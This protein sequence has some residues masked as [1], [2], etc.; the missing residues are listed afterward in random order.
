MAL[1][2]T[3][4]QIALSLN[5]ILPIHSAYFVSVVSNHCVKRILLHFKKGFSVPLAPRSERHGGRLPPAPSPAS[6]RVYILTEELAEE[7]NF[8]GSVFQELIPVDSHRRRRTSNLEGLQNC[9]NLAD[10]WATKGGCY[11]PWYPLFYA[12]VNSNDINKLYKGMK[13][14]KQ[15]LKKEII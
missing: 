15:K 4:L 8:R 9:P 3:I 14:P 2:L 7:Q 10:F 5:F 1:F 12:Y 13:L 11:P 6:L